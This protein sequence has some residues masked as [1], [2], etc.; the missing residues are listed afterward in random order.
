[1]R[2]VSALNKALLMAVKKGNQSDV[3][4]LINN[5]ADV[6]YADGRGWTACLLAACYG[7]LEILKYCVGECDGDLNHTLLNGKSVCLLAAEQGHLG[8]VKYCIEEHGADVNYADDRG[9][10]ACLSA[11]LGCLLYTST[12]TRD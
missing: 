1:M 5:G 4:S 8:I 12:S 7:Y 10:T 9:W 2:N 6:N 3:M 11:S